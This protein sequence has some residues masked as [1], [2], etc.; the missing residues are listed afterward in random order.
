M[1]TPTYVSPFTGTVVTPTD[2]SYY[3]LSF[4]TA[5]TLAWPA[6]V[7]PPEVP[8]AR[9]IDCVASAAG[10]TITLP[11]A[12]EGT[13][14]ADILF[15]NLGAFSFNVVDA[16]G[17][18]S[19][20]ITAGLAKYVY[21][22]DNTTAA[23]VWENITFGASTSY[24]DATTL[25]S[26]GLTTINGKLATTQ[27]IAT[28]SATP[29]INDASRATTYVWEGGV[30]TINLPVPASLSTGWFIAFRNQGTGTLTIVPPSPALINGGEQIETNPGDS[31]FIMYDM[32][33]AGYVT[34]GWQTAA[35]VSFTAAT[36]DVD[37]VPG[38]TLSLVSFAP[39]IQTYI[40]QSKTRTTTLAVTLPAI[41]QVYMLVNNTDESGYDIT[42]QNSGSTQPPFIL[43]AGG[44][45]IL[46]SDGQALYSLNQSAAGTVYAVDGSAA[47]PSISFSNSTSTGLYLVGTN[48]MGVTAHGVQIAEFDGSNLLDPMVNFTA[49]V[50]VSGNSD[51]NGTLTAGLISGGTFV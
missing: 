9:I 21:L 40:A 41:T 46:L 43:S 10:L 5:Q 11:P 1:T 22:T 2:V 48:V 4:S 50:N 8:A 14:G 36:Y 25:A 34:V 35:N 13:L 20:T 38:D 47:V 18:Q 17:G 49:S 42:F 7:N 3:P 23:G 32:S 26:Y 30:G 16:D 39:I 31:G 12:D 37:A 45:A 44:V 19:L 33:S 27:N 15:R 24:A 51:I 6:A 28:V 29:T